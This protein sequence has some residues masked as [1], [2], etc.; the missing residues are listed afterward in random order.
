[1]YHST[2]LLYAMVAMVTLCDIRIVPRLGGTFIRATCHAP[3]QMGP[4]P[5]GHTHPTLPWGFAYTISVTILAIEQ[6]SGHTYQASVIS[7][8]QLWSQTSVPLTYTGSLSLNN[9]S[10]TVCSQHWVALHAQN[11]EWHCD[12]ALALYTGTFMPTPLE[13]CLH[14]YD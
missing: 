2:A 12:D 11:A 8:D 3:P 13:N 10:F 9:S 5:S 7:P 6:A 4:H 1:M 14:G